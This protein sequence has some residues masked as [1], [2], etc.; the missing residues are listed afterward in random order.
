MKRLIHN[1]C[2]SVRNCHVCQVGA[3]VE[4]I[5]GNP[6]DSYWDS[7]AAA[8]TVW[9]FEKRGLLFIEE[10]AISTTKCQVRRVYHNRYQI[11]AR[12]KRDNSRAVKDCINT[13]GNE[14]ICEPSVP[15]KGAYVAKLLWLLKQLTHR[16]AKHTQRSL[17]FQTFSGLIKLL[18]G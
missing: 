16:S 14:N 11:D 2:H 4:C 10:H 3:A 1:V 6:K 9:I 7:V 12:V 13:A 5:R 15:S 18:E 17:V 8:L